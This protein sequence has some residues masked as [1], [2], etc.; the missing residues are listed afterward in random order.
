MNDNPLF[1]LLDDIKYQVFAPEITTMGTCECRSMSR[2]GRKCLHCLRTN[3]GNTA[4]YN[5]ADA[6]L[7]ALNDM[8]SKQEKY[9]EHKAK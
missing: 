9:N 8:K 6:Y 7:R 4:S 3:L 2:G 5:L 1:N